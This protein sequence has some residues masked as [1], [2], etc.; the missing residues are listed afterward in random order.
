MKRVSLTPKVLTLIQQKY[1]FSEG[2]F[3]E[4][5]KYGIKN[6]VGWGGIILWLKILGFRGPQ[7]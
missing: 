7:K 2:K 4:E 5:F 6:E 1:T 3:Y